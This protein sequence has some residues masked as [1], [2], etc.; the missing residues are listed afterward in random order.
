M[1]WHFSSHASAF[2]FSTLIDIWLHLTYGNIFATHNS[3]STWPYGVCGQRCD[4]I[5]AATLNTDHRVSSHCGSHQSCCGYTLITP[6]RTHH[7]PPPRSTRAGHTLSHCHTAVLGQSFIFLT[8]IDFN[9]ALA[10]THP[11]S[12]KLLALPLLQTAPRYDWHHGR[13]HMQ[14]AEFNPLSPGKTLVHGRM[15]FT[16]VSSRFSHRRK[17]APK[18]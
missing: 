6:I 5:N 3:P 8:D 14:A 9:M 15:C 18:L 12:F 2:S 11:P 16:G 17:Q 4:N 13:I 1:K 10:N 7:G